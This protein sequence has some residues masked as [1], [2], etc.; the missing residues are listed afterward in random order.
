MSKYHVVTNLVFSKD[1]LILYVDGNKHSFQ[2]ADVSMI[3]L[4]A[5]ESE[6]CHYEIS[7]SGY[8]IFWPLLDEDISIDG[9]LGIKHKPPETLQKVIHT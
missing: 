6:R 8:G 9:L 3:L 1:Q 4:H 2:L 7:P 5:T